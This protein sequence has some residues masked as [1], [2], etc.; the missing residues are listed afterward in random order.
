[1]TGNASSLWSSHIHRSKAAF[2]LLASVAL[3]SCASSQRGSSWSQIT[4]LAAKLP[5]WMDSAGVPGLAIALIS[6]GKVTGTSAIGV[7]RE[8]SAERITDTTVFEA[9][10]LSKPVLAYMTMRLV[11]AGSITLDQPLSKILPLDSH[12]PRA[13]VVT[14]RMVLSHTTGLQNERIDRDTLAF[15][16]QPGSSWRY[17]G[18]GYTYLGHVLETVTHESLTQLATRLVFSPL[19]MKRSSFVWEERFAGDAATGHGTYRQPLTPGRPTIA[20]AAATLHT[21]VTDYARF[22]SAVANG[23]GLSDSVKAKLTTRA[24]DVANGVHW[25][26]GWGLEDGP[27]GPAIAHH[28]DNSSSGFTAFAWLDLTTRNGVVYLTNSTEGL[29]IV[30]PVMQEVSRGVHP[31]VEALGYE[32]YNAPSRSIRNA[33]YRA[34]LNDG[35]EAALEVYR[36]L[37]EKGPASAFDENLLNRLGYRFLNL[38]RSGDALAFF[39]ENAKAFPSSAN[40][41]DSLGDGFVAAGRNQDAIGAYRR[42]LQLD[43]SN[44]HARDMIAKLSTGNR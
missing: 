26:M 28:G 33:I 14:A 27:T 10:S 39:Q 19:G 5:Y 6:N 4:S 43:P 24:V 36:T 42:S 17:S 3:A 23:E 13:N 2:A 29:G 11:D 7:R 8:G 34:A 12:D 37:K 41:F 1:M 31:A 44:N 9:A 16:F 40:V 20:R 35:G 22:L 32:S 15:A 25:T 18:E 30:R 38:N 21:T